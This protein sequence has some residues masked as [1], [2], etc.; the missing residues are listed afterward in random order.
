MRLPT[1][2]IIFLLASCDNRYPDIRGI[3]GRDKTLAFIYYEK[4]KAGLLDTNRNIVLPAQFDNIEEWQT[5]NLIPID[6]GGKKINGGD[7]VDYKYHKYGLINTKGE[8]LF[9]P[10]FDHLIISDNSALVKVDSLYGFVDNKGNWLIKAK[11]KSATPFYK[12][13]AIVSEDDN[14]KFINKEDK[15]VIQQTFDTVLSFFANGVALVQKDKKV[16]FINYR[17]QYVLP[18][19]NYQGYGTYNWYH[20]KF[21]KNGKWF[22]IDTSGKIPVPEG[23]EE[24]ETYNEKGIVY[25]VGLQNNRQVK[26]RLD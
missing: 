10:Q 4:G 13:T 6:S 17:G 20:G 16:G 9:R 7:Y 15:L 12:G 21:M 23:F 3:E 22:L 14:F 26:V 11:Y 8:I 19:D 25:A 1:L 2:F 5:D 18:L 24:V